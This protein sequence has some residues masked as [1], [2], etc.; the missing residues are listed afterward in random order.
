MM[1]FFLLLWLISMLEPAKRA[2]IADYFTNF[3]LFQSGQSFMEQTS[4]IHQ[5]VKPV[6]A[7]N[8]MER[9][10]EQMKKK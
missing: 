9:F 8:P 4:A 6:Q 2:A 5:E 10:K 7:E 1:A 3:N